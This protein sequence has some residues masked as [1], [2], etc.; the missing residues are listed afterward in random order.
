[1]NQLTFKGGNS[2]PFFESRIAEQ[3]SNL[4]TESRRLL[5]QIQKLA[6]I[7]PLK[8]KSI[9]NLRKQEQ[10]NQ[11][12]SFGES[13]SKRTSKSPLLATSTLPK[14]PFTK[15]FKAPE[16]KMKPF[17]LSYAEY[18][19]KKYR[20]KFVAENFIDDCFLPPIIENRK[21]MIQDS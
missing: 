14:S 18:V 13:K 7:S 11:D 9:R 2:R 1:M 15:E 4:I 6:T 17:L 21:L 10:L 12:S 5:R 20:R 8:S 19:K 16:N 3:N